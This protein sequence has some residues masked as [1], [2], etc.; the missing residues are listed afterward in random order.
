MSLAKATPRQRAVLIAYLRCGS[1]KA[2]AKDL[3]IN[4]GAARSRIFQMLKAT[5][6][7]TIAE[8]AFRLGLEQR[9]AA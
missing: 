6:T 3:G 2:A 1:Y 5:E 7:K 9:R 8:A 4:E